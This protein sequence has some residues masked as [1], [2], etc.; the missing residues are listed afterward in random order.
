MAVCA[1]EFALDYLGADQTSTVLGAQPSEIAFLDGTGKM[2]PL[3]R[4]ALESH[5]TVGA[6]PVLEALVP[7]YEH[8]PSRVLLAR[9]RPRMAAVVRGVVCLPTALAPRLPTPARGAVKLEGEL[10]LA[11]SAAQMP[12][13]HVAMIEN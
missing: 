11:T 8:M 6:W 5:S 4:G 12:F 3:H 10:M 7:V 1:D 13:F 9:P 2:I